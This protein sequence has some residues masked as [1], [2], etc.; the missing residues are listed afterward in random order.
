MLE[1][2]E[3]V[4]VAEVARKIATHERSER[5]QPPEPSTR[6]QLTVSLVHNHLPRLDEHDVLKYDTD[7]SEVVLTTPITS[8]SPDAVFERL[9]EP[10]LGQA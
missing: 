2:G 7:A 1:R 8:E 3:R 4:S 9:L 10:A 6:R 5:D